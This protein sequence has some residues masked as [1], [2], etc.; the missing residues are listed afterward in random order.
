MPDSVLSDIAAA[1]KVEVE[2][3]IV[4]VTAEGIV[5]RLEVRWS[6]RDSGM[7]REVDRGGIVGELRE[8]ESV[9]G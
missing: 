5:G 3:A 8:S 6:P 7:V 4:V 9:E 1:V 2:L